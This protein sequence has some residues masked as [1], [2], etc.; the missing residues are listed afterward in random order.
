MLQQ[1]DRHGGG[2]AKLVVGNPHVDVKFIAV[3]TVADIA[4]EAADIRLREIAKTVVVQALERAID[5]KIIDVLAP[6]HR[7]LDASKRAAH[8]VDLGAMIVETILHLHVD[9]PAQCIEAESGIVGHDGDRPYRRCRNHVPV[10]GVAEGFVDAHTILIDRKSLR[11]AGD[12]GRNEAAEFQVRL[13]W[14]AT[15]CVGDD[16]GHLLLQG[17]RNIQRTSALDLCRTNRIDAGRHLVDVYSGARRGR[18]R[19]RIDENSPHAWSGPAWSSG[20]AGF[21]ACRGGINH[22]GGQGFGRGARRVF[23]PSKITAG[24]QTYRYRPNEDETHVHL[25]HPPDSF[26]RVD[27]RRLGADDTSASLAL[28]T[29]KASENL[30]ENFP[31]QHHGII[32]QGTPL[33]TTASTVTPPAT[34]ATVSVPPNA[35]IL[36]RIPVKPRPSR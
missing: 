33:G 23:G 6:L 26:R 2:R 28:S 4:I 24:T 16:T 14:I 15:H 19:S 21:D 27:V 12:G 32:Q 36:S 11:R 3:V 9:C 35:R 1:F 10:D 29:F 17:I 31:K 5:G 8:R 30:R 13:K 25:S 22:D 20:A 7:T 18:G 34:E